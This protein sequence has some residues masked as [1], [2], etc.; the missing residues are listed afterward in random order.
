[1]LLVL[2]ATLAILTSCSSYKRPE[3][4]ASSTKRPVD[5]QALEGS[6]ENKIVSGSVALDQVRAV[7]VS[8]DGE[9]KIAHY[10]HGLPQRTRP[11]SGR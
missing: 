10:R 3:S 6:I 2:A 9:T 1:V 4:V 5:Y 8:V 11:M 7:L